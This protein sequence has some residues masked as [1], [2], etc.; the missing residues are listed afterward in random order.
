MQYAIVLGKVV[1]YSLKREK[2]KYKS[3]YKLNQLKYNYV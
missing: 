2:L 3:I 1:W